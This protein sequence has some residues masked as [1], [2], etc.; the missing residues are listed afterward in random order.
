M[1]QAVGLLGSGGQADEVESYLGQDQEVVFRAVSSG[2][3]DGK[4]ANQI[5]IAQPGERQDIPVIAALGA[6]DLRRDMVGQW[7]FDNYCTV[8]AEEAR[9]DGK[10]KIGEGTV[11]AP[12]AVVTT[13]A[14]IGKHVIINIGATINHDAQI[15][16]YVTISPGVHIAG[17]VKIGDGVFIGIGASIGNNVSVAAGSVIGAGAVVIEDITAENSV[18]VGIPAKV[19]KQNEGWLREI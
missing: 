11:I 4:A 17:R 8:I 18:A 10:A 13:N 12:M 3:L 15:G 16:D 1:N 14:V 19:I 9:V 7:P 5:D 2:Y 6:P